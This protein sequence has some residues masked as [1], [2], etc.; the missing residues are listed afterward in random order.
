MDVWMDGRM[1]GWTDRQTKAYSN[2]C[3]TGHQLS[4]TAAQEG[5]L[6]GIF[7][8]DK[9]VSFPYFRKASGEDFASKLPTRKKRHASPFKLV[10]QHPFWEW[11][12]A[13]PYQGYKNKYHNLDYNNKEGWNKDYNLDYN[14]KER[15]NP[16]SLSWVRSFP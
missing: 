14:N 7:W 8:V 9:H 6:C 10:L 13:N 5:S 2:L 4:G 15:W 11:L 16:G 12:Y 3:S 1:N